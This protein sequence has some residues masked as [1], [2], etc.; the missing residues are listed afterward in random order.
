[1][2]SG[3]YRIAFFDYADVFEDFYP[4]Y[5]VDQEAFATRW[6]ATGNHAFVGLLQREVGDVIWYETSLSPRIAAARHEITGC[7]VKFLPSSPLH[8]VLWKAFYLPAAAWRW[9][10]VYRPFATLA[11]YLAPLSSRLWR[12]VWRDS[13]DCVFVQSYSSGRFDVLLLMARLLR[14]R[15]VAYHAGGECD[16]YLGAAVRRWSLKHAD[17]I[18]VSSASEA[19]RLAR[20][21]SVPRDKLRLILTPIDTTVYAPLDRN[22]A[23]RA[24]GLDV[25]RRYLLFVGR[26]DDQTKRVSAIIRSFAAIAAD[27]PTVDLVVVGGGQDEHALRSL[28]DALVPG[29]VRFTGWISG[30]LE[31]AH[32][33]NAAE[34][35]VLAS[36][37]EGFPT[38]VGEAMACGTPV[39]SADVGGVSELVEQG[40]TGWLVAPGN[41]RALTDTMAGVLDGRLPRPSRLQVRQAAEA[42]VSR[43][44]VAQGL[45]ECFEC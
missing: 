4:H 37:R 44:A 17:R 31:K 43:K 14:L 2:S 29:R 18:I 30:D 5:D 19:D 33:Y 41:D 40:V 1:V 25:R 45:R 10:R 38:V 12:A 26:L 3:R 35:L 42:R 13:V 8:R 23:C 28:A 22:M 36:R 6:A 9:R 20:R 7:L 16:R 11:S 34:C 32:W 27:R 15:F 39:V 21:H 24:S